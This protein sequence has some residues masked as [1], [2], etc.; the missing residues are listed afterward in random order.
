MTKNLEKKEHFFEHLNSSINVK[1]IEVYENKAIFLECN[2]FNDLTD[3][4][5]KKDKL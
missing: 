2:K 5:E 3:I 4:L 1:K